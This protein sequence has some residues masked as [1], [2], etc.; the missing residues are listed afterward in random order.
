MNREIETMTKMWYMWLNLITHKNTGV[1][2][3]LPFY[4]R[5]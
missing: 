2:K 3:L 1:E 4:A 5:L